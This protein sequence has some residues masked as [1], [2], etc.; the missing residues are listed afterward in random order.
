MSTL[1]AGVELLTPKL[2]IAR[3]T[4]LKPILFIVPTE[5]GRLGIA[6]SDPYLGYSI[7]VASFD[8]AQQVD[9]IIRDVRPGGLAFGLP[10]KTT[11]RNR[12][13]DTTPSSNIFKVR[14][15][16]IASHSWMV[17]LQCKID[18]QASLA[19]ALERKQS[20]WEMWEEIELP[21]ENEEDGKPKHLGEENSHETDS[22]IEPSI[23]AAVAL[24]FFLW[25]ECGGWRNTFG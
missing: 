15:D 17:H 23:Q 24:I 3:L 5:R 9:A 19:D 25:E 13:I 11:R 6:L 1:A 7:P 2:F 21:E 20:E 10:L 12:V 8:T 22:E 16:L 4:P 14:D 18:H